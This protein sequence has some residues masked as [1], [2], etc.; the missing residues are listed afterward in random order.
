[1]GARSRSVRGFSAAASANPVTVEHAFD[2]LLGV[3]RVWF[4][5]DGQAEFVICDVATYERDPAEALRVATRAL[6]KR[7]DRAV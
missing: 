2:E 7:A 5:R 6:D 4:T 3:G 1:M